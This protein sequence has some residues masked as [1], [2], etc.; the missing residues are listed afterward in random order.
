MLPTIR[1]L[2]SV[3][4]ITKC[5]VP[6]PPEETLRL[7]NLHIFCHALPNSILPSGAFIPTIHGTPFRCLGVVATADEIAR[8]LHHRRY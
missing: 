7:E 2:L 1:G 6:T 3:A 4:P 5:C 8:E